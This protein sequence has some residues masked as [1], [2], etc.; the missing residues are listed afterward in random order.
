MAAPLWRR[1]G[2]TRLELWLPRDWPREGADPRWRRI[3]PG[4]RTRE[5]RGLEGLAPTKEVVVWSPAADTLLLRARLPTRNPAKI[6]Q[7]LPY[8]LEEQLVD[9]P[10]ALHFAFTHEADG[11]LA[12]AVTRRETMDR[13]L[14]ALAASG[15]QPVRLA[16]VT[17]SLP[18]ARGAWTL[19]FGEE[20][21]V[22]RSG[23]HSGFSGPRGALPPAWLK[24]A[25]GEAQSENRAPERIL[26]VDA[27]ADLD[28][29]AW[30][31]ALALPVETLRAESAAV[32]AP[33]LNLL[34]QRYAPRGPLAGLWRAYMPAAAL[35]AAWL[36][37][38][39]VFDAIEW[40][41]LS[42]SVRADDEAMRALLLKS[43]PDTRAILD[44]AEQMRRG[45]ETLIASTGAAGPD[46][47]LAL[48]ERVLPAIEREPRVRLQG[49]EYAERALN[50]RLA[51]AEPEAE[52]VAQTLRAQRLEVDVQRSGGEAQ[53]RVRAAAA[54]G[55]Q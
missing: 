50:L 13:W 52:S 1:P 48:L 11:A 55:S 54:K 49:I 9:P 26:L 25:L 10:E 21:M 14:A 41:R 27:P 23:L 15:L 18:L 44:P 16:P 30:S 28:V 4:E 51:A 17:L 53:L 8:A 32:P 35:L 39:F 6:A 34:Q 47:M 20:E 38:T 37:G 22:L 29:A 42:R 7:A 19:A 46:D 40:A 33:S 5:G 2:A 12:V 43:F 3:A 36:A 24:A 31:E 45:L